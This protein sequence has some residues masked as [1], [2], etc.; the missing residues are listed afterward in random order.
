[1]TPETRRGSRGYVAGIDEAVAVQPS[2]ASA[3]DIAVAPEC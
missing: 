1:M 3:T 2:S